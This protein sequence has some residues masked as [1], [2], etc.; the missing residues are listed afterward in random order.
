MLVTVG[1]LV[2]DV[3]VKLKA[4]PVRGH[5]TPV[6]AARVRG[7]SA[8]NVAALDAELGG[9]PR[10]VGQVGDDHV[11]HTLVDD[12][13][14]RGVATTVSHAGG[15]GVIITVV[16][17]GT[18]S[19]MID[20]GASRRLQSID[21]DV[22]EAAEQLFV[23]A[24]AFVDDPFASAIDRLLGEAADRRIPVTIGGPSPT[25]LAA[26]GVAAFL[27]LCDALRPE[28]VILRGETHTLLDIGPR[29][30]I[31][32]AATTIVTNTRRPTLVATQDDTRSVG[33][34]AVDSI[35]DRTGAG[36]G[37]VAGFLS[38]R[39]TGADPFAATDAGHRV[40]ADVLGQLGPT[41][42]RISAE[43]TP[44]PSPGA[45]TVAS[46]SVGE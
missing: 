35:I 27:S 21:P 44:S 8:A 30:A 39:R 4:D 17:G 38:A 14:R 46:G 37:F 9:T 43:P 29:G 24:G 12:L 34:R 28:H 32:G 23:S 26:I 6:R 11:G 31:E 25:E 3:L 2:E 20:R 1:D 15:T 5:D 18:R 36:D 22:L 40:A 33:V 7:G 16:G 41:T 42:G 10:F 45:D 13:E 19:R